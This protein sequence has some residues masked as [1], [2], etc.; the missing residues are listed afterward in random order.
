MYKLFQKTCRNNEFYIDYERA[1]TL[2][3][4]VDFD[5]DDSFWAQTDGK[6]VWINTH[7]DFTDDDLYW[8]LLHECL[9][10][11]VKRR[12]GHEL[13]ETTE[14]RVMYELDARLI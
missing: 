14:H 5:V 1:A 2:N 4:E 3:I 6:V 11:M 10:G 8:T 9:H 12:T 7:C 13:C